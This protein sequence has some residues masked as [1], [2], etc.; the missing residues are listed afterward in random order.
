ML[1]TSIGYKLHIKLDGVWLLIFDCSLMRCFLVV[2]IWISTTYV[3]EI[4]ERKLYAALLCIS[5]FISLSFPL[6]SLSLS[7]STPFLSH[8]RYIYIYIMCFFFVYS[9]SFMLLKCRCSVWVSGVW[10]NIGIIVCLR[11]SCCLCLSQQWQ[12]V[13]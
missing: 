4:N 11:F 8:Q 3:P 7:L 1:I 13:S 10:M 12:K 5:G 9:L 2:Q 6:S